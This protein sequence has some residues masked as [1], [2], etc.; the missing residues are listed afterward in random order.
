[1]PATSAGGKDAL[2]AAKTTGEELED[3]VRDNEEL[4]DAAAVP[5]Q[6]EKPSQPPID[7]GARKAW[8]L[9]LPLGMPR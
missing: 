3:A 8:R 5:G 7:M 1:M 2:A 9:R 6:G 4:E